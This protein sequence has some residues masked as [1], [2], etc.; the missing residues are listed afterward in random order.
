M[1]R[2]TAILLILAIICNGILLFLYWIHHMFVSGL[3]PF[4]GAAVSLFF[5]LLAIP[6]A[7]FALKRLVRYAKGKPGVSPAT[8]FLLGS[9]GSL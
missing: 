7:I 6:V 3:N 1:I 2:K 4:L 8:L 9:S 5:L